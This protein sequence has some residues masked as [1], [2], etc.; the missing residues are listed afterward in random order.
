MNVDWY[1]YEFKYNT[2]ASS[3]KF[4]K[5]SH[6]YYSVYKDVL[7]ELDMKKT[8]LL[9]AFIVVALSACSKSEQAEPENTVINEPSSTISDT[10]S[11]VKESATDLK[12]IAKSKIEAAKE[13]ATEK[14]ETAKNA[15]TEKVEETKKSVADKAEDTKKAI[16]EKL[17]DFK[18]N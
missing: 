13:D 17:G 11:T 9:L 18:P 5:C 4:L 7:V 10:M 12:D 15:V 6:R 2:A 1:Q 3:R 16:A 14:V 8:N